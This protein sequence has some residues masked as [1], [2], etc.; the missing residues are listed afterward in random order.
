MT[1]GRHGQHGPRA[2]GRPRARDAQGE[3]GERAPGEVRLQRRLEDEVSVA[4]NALDE[5]GAAEAQVSDA[6][7]APGEELGDGGQVDEPAKDIVVGASGHGHIGQ[8]RDGSGQGDAVVGHA[9]LGA[10]EQEARA[11]AV[12]GATKQVAG[13]G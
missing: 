12:L 3:K 9:R 7:A 6:D 1:L 11:V 8:Q 13:P 4:V 2:R 10:C 5:Q